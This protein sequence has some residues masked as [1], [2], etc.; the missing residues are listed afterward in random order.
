MGLSPDELASRA[1]ARYENS[2]DCKMHLML[3]SN[4]SYSLEIQLAVI[5]IVWRELPPEAKASLGLLLV[6]KEFNKQTQ[7]YWQIEATLRTIGFPLEKIRLVEIN[8]A[9]IAA[10]KRGSMPESWE[11]VLE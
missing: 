1:L 6:A 10:L 9:T 11:A 3:K 4:S 7:E 5:Q 8:Q 2:V